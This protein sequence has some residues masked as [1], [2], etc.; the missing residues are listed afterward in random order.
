VTLT[1]DKREEF[2][3]TALDWFRRVGR[4]RFKCGD[5]DF[6]ESA[7]GMAIT[8]SLD[9]SPISLDW[10]KNRII[11][12]VKDALRTRPGST[13]GRFRGKRFFSLFNDDGFVY[14]PACDG[15]SVE[16]GAITKDL[17]DFASQTH[18]EKE[19]RVLRGVIRG[20]TQHEIGR[21]L[22]IS[23]S[24]VCLI[25]AGIRRKNASSKHFQS[26][27]EGLNR[28]SVVES[29]QSKVCT[30]CSIESLIGNFHRQK[31]GKYGV[32]PICKDCASIKNKRRYYKSKE[33]AKV[34]S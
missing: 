15:G 26:L 17:L 4:H 5:Q 27:F 20:E 18:T 32:K 28:S 9:T 3:A 34:K 6:L 33:K 22:G 2:A 21:D 23:R 10:C 31:G 30:E 14:E 24:A 12:D 11:W 8:R 25:A 7:A 19:M 29:S 13:R 1:K 16:E